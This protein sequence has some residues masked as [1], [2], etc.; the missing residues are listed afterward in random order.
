MIAVDCMDD[1]ISLD[2]KFIAAISAQRNR[3]VNA[4]PDNPL[5]GKIQVQAE[6]SSFRW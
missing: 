1:K 4:R 6:R 5:T 3:E 2:S